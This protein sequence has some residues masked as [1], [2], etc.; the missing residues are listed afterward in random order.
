M[1]T[2]DQ[3]LDTFRQYKALV[4]NQTGKTIKTLRDDKGGKYTSKEFD[5][6]TASSGIFRQ[7]TAPAA[8]QQNRVAEHFNH[9]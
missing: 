1:K 7:R 4:E 6:L 5:A 8:P 9:H 2:K 3:A